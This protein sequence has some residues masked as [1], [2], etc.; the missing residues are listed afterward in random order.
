ML[1]VVKESSLEK[2]IVHPDSVFLTTDGG[3]EHRVHSVKIPLNLMFN[4]LRANRLFAMRRYEEI[5]LKWKI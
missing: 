5:Q 2:V 3:P 4:E 1:N